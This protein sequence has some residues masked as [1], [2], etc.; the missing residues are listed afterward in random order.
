MFL[1]IF[2][3][4]AILKGEDEGRT[5]YPKGCLVN[6]ETMIPNKSLRIIDEGMKIRAF[7]RLGLHKSRFASNSIRASYLNMGL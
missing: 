5:V 1:K 4:Q 3:N 2:P 7:L 6:H